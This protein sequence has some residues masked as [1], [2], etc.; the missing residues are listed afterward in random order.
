MFEA[1]F[2]EFLRQIFWM[3]VRASTDGSIHYICIDWRHVFDVLAAGR[4]TYRELK[5]IAV[6]AK[7]N[8]GMGAFYRSQHE[9]IAVFKNGRAPH[10]NNFGLGE[11]G[12]YRTNLWTYAGV[13]TFRHGRDEDLAAHPTVKPVA[14]VADAIRDCSRRNDVVLDAFGGSGTTLIAAEKTG[15]RACLIELDP[16]YVDVTIR[17]WQALTGQQAANTG[18][19][20]T[21][22]QT[23]RAASRQISSPRP[24]R[25]RNGTG[26]SDES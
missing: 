1:E 24:R 9:L 7:T 2:L 17:R 19:G 12:R 5:N 8:G 20:Q 11:N 4:D 22:D 14:L 26:G 23:E 15:R 6:W 18:T 25:R 21:F 16:L 3:L 10:V 13:N